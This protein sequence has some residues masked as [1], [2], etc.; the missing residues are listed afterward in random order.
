MR[1][2][3]GDLGE[4]WFLYDKQACRVVNR[5]P[6]LSFHQ[7]GTAPVGLRALEEATGQNFSEPI[8]KGLSWVMGANALGNDLRNLEKGLIWDCIQPRRQALKYWDAALS[9]ANIPTESRKDG[10]SVRH[11]A[12]P[13]HFG[14]LLYAFGRC[15]LPKAEVAAR[16]ERAG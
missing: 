15:G 3:Q 2:L 7:D 14:W 9:L 1:A 5:Y 6:V 8:Y 11:E 10:L 4:W 13:D 12:C 16:T